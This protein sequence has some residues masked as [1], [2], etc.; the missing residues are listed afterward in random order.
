MYNLLNNYYTRLKSLFRL[1]LRLSF[2]FYFYFNFIVLVFNNYFSSLIVRLRM[3]IY[4]Y[5]NLSYTNSYCLTSSSGLGFSLNF[6]VFIN[7]WLNDLARIWAASISMWESPRQIK[8]VMICFKMGRGK[9]INLLSK[10]H[11][12]TF[13]SKFFFKSLNVSTF[14][15]WQS[16]GKTSSYALRAD[17]TVI[18]FVS[19]T[20][21]VFG[22]YLFY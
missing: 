6:I 16:P 4:I 19:I 3:L 9:K 12:I 8:L 7:A 10:T 21:R 18:V 11:K 15:L 2:C 14:H 13:S 17:I 22:K 20:S 1:P 5:S